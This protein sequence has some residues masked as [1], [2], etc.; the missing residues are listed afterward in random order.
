MISIKVE[1]IL[2]GAKMPTKA[3]ITDAGYDLYSPV[4][5]MIHRQSRKLIDIGIR[6]ELPE[7]YEAQIRSRSGM[8]VKRGVCVLN[9]VGTIDCGFKGSIMTLLYNSTD[10]PVYFKKGDRISQLVIKEVPKVTLVE[11]PV[12]KE[13]NRGINGVGSSGE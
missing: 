3:Y 7:W 9:G 13:T 11:G 2:E 6:I 1:R 5:F 4:D 8:A 10:A 12:A